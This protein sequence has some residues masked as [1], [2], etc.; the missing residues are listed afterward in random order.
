MSHT[1]FAPA[2]RILKAAPLNFGLRHLLAAQD[3][4]R[5]RQQ[6]RSLPRHM[7]DDIGATPQ[8]ANAEASRPV[9]DVPAH[10]VE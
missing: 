8:S 7:L 2:L 3:V 9:W 10:W 6:L 5:S 1:S 4:W